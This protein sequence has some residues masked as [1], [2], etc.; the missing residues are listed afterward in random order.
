MIAVTEAGV[1]SA[2]LAWLPARGWQTAHGPDIGPGGPG[3]ERADDSVVVLE[4]RRRT[5]RAR[6]NQKCPSKCSTTP[7]AS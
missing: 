2:A 1:E 7:I 4:R 5:A 6:L 3:A